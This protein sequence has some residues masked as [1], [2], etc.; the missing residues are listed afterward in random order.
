[1][2]LLYLARDRVE[3]QFLRDLLGSERIDSVI[4]GDYLAGAAGEL[5]VDIFPAVWVV[6]DSDLGRA[7]VVLEGFLDQGREP[8]D[9]PAWTCPCCGEQVDGGFDR[10][11]SCGTARPGTDPA[12][13]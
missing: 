2:Q 11:W 4:L 3:A 12:G 1:M 13:A 7:R 5:P 8:V 10:C 9:S 6:E